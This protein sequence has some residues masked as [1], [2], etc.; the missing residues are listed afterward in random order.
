MLTGIDSGRTRD[1]RSL[2]NLIRAL[3]HT[4]DKAFG[5]NLY[6]DRT[7]SPIRHGL[8]HPASHY[9][10][11]SRAHFK[12][13]VLTWSLVVPPL[14]RNLAVPVCLEHP[15]LAGLPTNSTGS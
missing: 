1:G 12:G 3:T 13:L 7:G 8:I 4:R 15:R 5:C 10:C 6:G 9:S 14:R 2:E 11:A